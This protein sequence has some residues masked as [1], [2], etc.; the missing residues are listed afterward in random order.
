MRTLIIFLAIAAL[1]PRGAMAQTGWV[2]FSIYPVDRY[3][4]KVDG[5]IQPKGTSG[6]QLTEGSHRLSFH[7]PRMSLWDTIVHVVADSVIVVRKVL[8]ASL[9][10]KEFIARDK[11]V[12]YKK[13]MFVGVPMLATVTTGAIC[14]F[15]FREFR[16]ARSSV[17]FL[18]TSYVG[19]GDPTDVMNWRMRDVPDAL[20]RQDESLQ[21]AYFWGGAAVAS[22][23]LLYIG[24]RKAS[25]L[26]RPVFE[27][28]EGLRFQGITYVPGGADAVMVSLQYMW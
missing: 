3:Q 13:A 23:V 19:L 12:S 24:A 11:G 6:V 21:R 28:K 2:K 5:V 20:Q 18:Q 1:S 4:C 17:E 22:S 9:E 26:E 8:L 27:D 7:A 16:E 25:R 15:A 10:Y 14:F